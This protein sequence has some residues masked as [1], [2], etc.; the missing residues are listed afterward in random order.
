MTKA[1]MTLSDI[2]SGLRPHFQEYDVR[3]LDLDRDVNLIIQRTLEYG[4]WDE[5]RWLFGIYGGPRIRTFVQERGERLLSRVTFN[6]WRKLLGV[7]HWRHS[8]FP[9]AKG[10]VWD[11]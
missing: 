9:T 11:R 2:P 10:E 7:R 6:Y 1:P 8:P 3:T 4:T 5:V